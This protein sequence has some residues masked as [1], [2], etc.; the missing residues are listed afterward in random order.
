MVN[1]KKSVN[2]SIIVCIA[3]AV[4]LTVFVFLGPILFEL[5]LVA[6]RGLTPSGDP[7]ANIKTTFVCCFYPSAVFAGIILYSLL[8]LLFNIKK[9]EIFIRANVT[10]LRI[11][12]WCCFI[13]GIITFVGCFFY[14]PFMF[15]AAAG[16]FLGMLLR[17]LKNVMQS[18]VEI[19]EENELTI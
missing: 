7:L 9:G 8:K 13:I 10:C 5:Y 11:V 14:M 6:Y 3:L 19:R 16:G 18:A 15:I 4:I 12:S 1:H 2:I 17:V